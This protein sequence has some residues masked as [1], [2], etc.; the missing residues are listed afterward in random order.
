S[1]PGQAYIEIQGGLAQTQGEYVSMP[2]AAEWSWLEAYG[3]IESDANLVHGKD[4]KTAYES[5]EREL[6]QHLPRRKMNE[7]LAN[8]AKSVADRAPV[9]VLHQGSGWGALEQIRRQRASQKPFAPSALSFPGESIEEQ[10][11]PWLALLENGS[12]PYR[13]PTDDPGSLMVQPEW[14]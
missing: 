14:R 12:L 3:L 9:E 2:S 8:S 7:L 13:P 4:W 11:K 10:Q 5:V 1:Q 6:E